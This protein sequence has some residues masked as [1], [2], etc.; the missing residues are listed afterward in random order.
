MTL[1]C[2]VF[3]D[4]PAKIY[5]FKANNRKTRKECD[6]CSKLTIKEHQ[7]D[8]NEL[9][10]PPSRFELVTCEFELDTNGFELVNRGFKLVLLNLN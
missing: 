9:Q 7:D 2:W 6:I 1:F 8:V 4:F 10:T 5:L 3:I